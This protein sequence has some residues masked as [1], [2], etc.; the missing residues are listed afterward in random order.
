MNDIQLPEVPARTMHARFYKDSSGSDRVEISFAGS[1]DTVVQDITPDVMS[2]Y[3]EEWNA[4]CD[5]KPLTQ[6]AG[7]PLTDIPGMNDDRLKHYL[8][9]NV[10]NLEELAALSDIQ[11][12]GVGHGVLTERKTART[13]LTERMADKKQRF[14]DKMEK[15]MAAATPVKN[16]ESDAKLDKLIATTEQ[17][18]QNILALVQAL[19]PRKPGRPKREQSDG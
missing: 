18:N 9:M 17:V 14:Q 19:Q 8:H 5:G 7:T 15:A 13:I 6:R 1:K 10:H 3:R 4:Y 11:C 12:Q 16:E 2:Q